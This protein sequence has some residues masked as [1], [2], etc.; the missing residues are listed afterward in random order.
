D[1]GIVEFSKGISEVVIADILAFL[2]ANCATESDFIALKN[3]LCHNEASQAE[4]YNLNNNYPDEIILFFKIMQDRQILS[5]ITNKDLS[6]WL[7]RKFRYFK[8]GGYHVVHSQRTILDKL[9]VRLT[10]KEKIKEL[11]IHFKK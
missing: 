4:Y 5:K 10:P 1:K 2:K 8:D 7:H 6:K 9:N 3:E 11:N